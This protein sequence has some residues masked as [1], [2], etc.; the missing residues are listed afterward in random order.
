MNDDL[1]QTI[2]TL[3]NALKPSQTKIDTVVD[4]IPYS[5]KIAVRF[6]RN[7]FTRKR[8]HTISIDLEH[9]EKE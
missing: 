8:G 1:I 5:A 9:S 2:S 4:G 3:R 6:W 7:P